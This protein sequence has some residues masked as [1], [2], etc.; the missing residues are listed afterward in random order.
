MRYCIRCLGEDITASVFWL[1]DGVDV[2]IFGGCRTHVGAVTM[3]EPHGEIHTLI[4][5]GHRDDV[6]SEHWALTL[7][8]HWQIPV[9]VRCGIHYEHMNREQI[10][11]IIAAT[12]ALLERILEEEIPSSGENAKCNRVRQ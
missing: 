3:A 6:I 4:R 5:E 10:D 1:D 12:Q 8:T 2:G 9:C 7:A 11:Q